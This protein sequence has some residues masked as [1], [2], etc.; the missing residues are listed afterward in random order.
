MSRS[1][2]STSRI[3][4]DVYPKVASELRTA[5][6]AA[7]AHAHTHARTERDQ[8]VCFTRRPSRRSLVS[9]RLPRDLCPR[10]T[11]RNP[12][13]VLNKHN[14]SSLRRRHRPQ[15]TGQ[16]YVSP[17]RTTSRICWLSPKASVVAAER[18]SHLRHPP[19]KP[20]CDTPGNGF[21]SSAPPAGP[22]AARPRARRASPPAAPAARPRARRVRQRR[23]GS[24]E[25]HVGHP[26]VSRAARRHLR[27]VLSSGA[28]LLAARTTQLPRRRR[29]LPPNCHGVGTTARRRVARAAA[30]APRVVE[31]QCRPRVI[32]RLQR[33]EQLWLLGRESFGGL[34]RREQLWHLR[35]LVSPRAP[36]GQAS[37]G[38][39]WSLQRR[40][41]RPPAA[42]A[43]PAA[44]P[45]TSS[46]AERHVG[47]L[48]GRVQRFRAA[49]QSG[50]AASR[51]R[52]AQAAGDE[53]VCEVRDNPRP[54][55]R[56][57]M[58]APVVTGGGAFA[59]DGLIDYGG[60]SSC[61]TG[62]DDTPARRSLIPAT[63]L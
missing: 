61:S 7:L 56:R 6:R 60:C 36:L 51:P 12:V 16:M 54:A 26:Q 43:V 58:A 2:A 40:A 42:R 44:P 37:S 50:Q 22:P 52:A 34:Q 47:F 1:S 25:R 48:S 33:R 24:I 23:V 17:A 21:P 29:S 19:P 27:R 46:Q 18:L 49:A 14:G 59:P 38:A 4:L 3:S 13:T 53:E 41:A 62:G 28:R 31:R 30:P 11:G 20:S 8:V 15:P 32:W 57:L 63:T 35:H 39:S 55:R 9:H 10:R 5:P 45:G